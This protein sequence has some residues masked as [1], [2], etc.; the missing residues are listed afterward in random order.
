MTPRCTVYLGL[1]SNQGDRRANL[2]EGLK[3]LRDGVKIERV[4]SL[5]DTAPVGFLDQ[6]RFLNIVC[7]G[8]TLLS[9]E[10]LLQLA[11][12]VELELG[13][14]ERF[15]NAPRTLDVDILLYSDMIVDT[16]VLTV[17]HPRFPA[18]AFVL[19]PLAEIAS[20]VVHPTLRKTARRLLSELPDRAGVM[21]AKGQGSWRDQARAALGKRAG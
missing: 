1:G 15:R 16:S 5:Y 19:E 7:K 21:L 18:R 12:R 13:R 17:P 11:K 9:P 14:T 4:S 8:R 3:R 2:L 6:P 20:A 10:D